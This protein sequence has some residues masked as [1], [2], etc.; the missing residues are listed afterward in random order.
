[1][2]RAVPASVCGYPARRITQQAQAAVLAATGYGQ[3]PWTGR[4][5]AAPAALTAPGSTSGSPTVAE[6]GG[7]LLDHLEVDVKHNET[8][9]FTELLQPLD[10]DG[11][12][13]TFDALHPVR[14]NLNWLAGEKKAHYIVVVKNN[15]PLL[16]ARIKA[17]P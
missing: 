4:P 2:A 16:Q 12:V 13:V 9:H 11:A 17:L 10:L 7:H 3:W 14:T 6:H 5:A 15:Q 8:S 1:M